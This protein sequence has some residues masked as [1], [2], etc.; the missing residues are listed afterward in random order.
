MMAH[1]LTNARVRAH[2]CAHRHIHT[3]ILTHTSHT[4]TYA[5]PLSHVQQQLWVAPTENLTQ[6]LRAV[7]QLRVSPPSSWL[8][9]Y[10]EAS[11][12]RLSQHS[13]DQV[14]RVYVQ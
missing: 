2:T 9:S 3:N 7:S 1:T 11:S 14:C 8:S 6:M 5:I 10:Y 12:P 13:T 4:Y